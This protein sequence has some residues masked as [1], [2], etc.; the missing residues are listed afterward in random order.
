MAKR[1]S[2][3]MGEPRSS[4]FAALG[5]V[6]DVFGV[7]E[8]ATASSMVFSASF[9]GLCSIDLHGAEDPGGPGSKDSLVG[10][11]QPGSECPSLDAPRIRL[12]KKAL[13]ACGGAFA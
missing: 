4:R 9:P 10:Y 13:R 12:E 8:C 11:Q 1:V 5:G 2:Q 6:D 7:S 3:E